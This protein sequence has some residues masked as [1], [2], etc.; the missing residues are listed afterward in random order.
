[1]RE[2]VRVCILDA[3]ML[4]CDPGFQA[5]AIIKLCDGKG[6]QPMVTN[7]HEYNYVC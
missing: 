3:I 7:S 1:M 6:F 5:F 4:V 2:L